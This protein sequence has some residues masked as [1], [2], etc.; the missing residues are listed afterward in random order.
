MIMVGE[1]RPGLQ[2]PAILGSQPLECLAEPAQTPGV[3]EVMPFQIGPAGHHVSSA[4]RHPV[5]R[6]VRPITHFSPSRAEP[7]LTLVTRNPATPS[8]LRLAGGKAWVRLC[9]GGVKPPHSKAGSARKKV[10]N[11]LC[12]V[13]AAALLRLL[14]GRG[15]A[16]ALCF[17]K[18]CLT[19]LPV[20]LLQKQKA[21]VV[22]GLRKVRLEGNRFLQLL[23]C[24][25]NVSLLG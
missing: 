8:T 6:T 24:G 4:F 1:N 9:E 21:E 15:I 2:V 11:H 5:H 18:L 3:L 20:S 19:G 7:A 13:R 22:M 10:H 12:R 16:Q 14:G 25:R 23:D 17:L